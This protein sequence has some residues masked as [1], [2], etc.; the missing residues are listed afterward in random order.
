MNSAL[1]AALDEGAR[2]VTPNRRLAR[3]LHREFDLVQRARGLRAWTTPSILPHPQWL[4][5]LWNEAVAREAVDDEPLLLTPM[6]AS[7]QWRQ[8]V[9]ADADSVPL[10]DGH[11]AAALA[12]E[13]WSIVHQWGAGGESWRAWRSDAAPDD[14]AVFAR[15]ADTHQARMR[16]AG[17][18]DLP[19]VPDALVRVA[20][21]LPQ[22]PATVLAGFIEITPQQ[23]RWLAALRE[24]GTDVRELDTLPDTDATPLRAA[25]PTP[26]DELGAAFGWARERAI[27]RPGSRIGVV[28]EDLHARREEVLALAEDVLGPRFTEASGQRAPFEISLGPRLAEA[29][30]VVTALDLIALAEGP[31]ATGAAAALLRSPYVAG[32]PGEWTVRARVERQWLCEGKHEVTLSNAVNALERMSPELATRWRTAGDALRARRRTTPREWSDAWRSWLAAA[33]WP[34]SRALDSAEYQ[35]REAWER[36][37]LEFAALGTVA[38]RLSASRAVATLQ[39][40]ARE[41][42]FQPEG[43]RAPVTILGLL[44][45]AGIAFDALWISGLASDRWPAAP[46]PNPLLPL[47]W[48]RERNVAHATPQRERE[49][50]Q[51]LTSL[52]ARSA[53]EV[54]FSFPASVDEHALSPSALILPFAPCELRRR[55][56]SWIEDIARSGGLEAIADERAPP[57]PVGSRVS[58]GSRIVAM[59]S[60]CPFQAVVRGRLRTEPWPSPPAGLTP[61]ERGSLAHEAL[62]AFWTSVR[63]QP[64]LLALAP[65]E[66]ATRIDAAINAALATIPAERWRSLPALLREGEGERLRRLLNAW[67]TIE[68]ERPAFVAE[69]LEIR[70]ALRLSDIELSLQLDRIDAL[71][72]GGVAILDY[73]TG[74]IERPRQWFDPR[75]R[76]AQI[77]LYTLAQRAAA[78]ERTVRAA[79]YVELRPEGVSVAGIAADEAAWPALALAGN[80]AP[81]GTWSALETW[82]RERLG[83]LAEEIAAGHAAVAPRTKPSPCRNCGM[84][85]V[86]R[87]ES[88]R[89]VDPED[90]SDE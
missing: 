5:T 54:V 1:L 61:L 14:P 4:E 76:A 88:V 84:Q 13:A 59:Q 16:A 21:H 7:L 18:R 38:P 43:D 32:A 19:Q 3:W 68:R 70:V 73:K 62:K 6:Q 90:A 27:A 40:L 8:I 49:Y 75:P 31:L 47:T 79:G 28:V 63:D 77:G 10:L 9:E 45:A 50:A 87:I 56:S 82:W 83:A 30:L 34:G 81:G 69:A 52:F 44:E 89:A 42:R 39:T 37:L 58:G 20:A 55:N 23:R 80:V 48:Q 22:A 24:A 86:C 46:R 74:Q 35:A 36:L 65:G 11:G 71:G 33:G 53:R 60:D 2:V 17:S 67:L 57:I 85:P 66:L 26:R 15:W 29:P 64:T 25:A 78:P 12:A 51:A 41:Q 72:D